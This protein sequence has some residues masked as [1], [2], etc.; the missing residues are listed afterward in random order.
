MTDKNDGPAVAEPDSVVSEEDIELEAEHRVALTE[1]LLEYR[2]LRT[3]NEYDP[4]EDRAYIE[5]L[6][7]KDLL[8]FWDSLVGETINKI[9]QNPK[10]DLHDAWENADVDGIIAEPSQW[11]L[12][13]LLTGEETDYVIPTLINVLGQL[14][15]DSSS[16]TFSH[17]KLE[18]ML[19][20]CGM[21]VDEDGYIIDKE[22][23]EFKIPYNFDAH[24]DR[25]FKPFTETAY[26][27]EDDP[28]EERLAD[29]REEHD[30]PNRHHSDRIHTEDFG[31][32]IPSG[33]LP[34]TEKDQIL[35]DYWYE[36]L[37]LALAEA[38]TENLK[39]IGPDSPILT[40]HEIYLTYTQDAEAFAA[41]E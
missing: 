23:G 16:I 1:D 41:E 5:E 22:T 18:F 39:G 6:S 30:E 40:T 2:E 21:A 20:V 26:D 35:K 19:E 38:L 8:L 24:G 31:G 33:I 17:S 29:M 15:Q 12:K 36:M 13:K 25:T 11:Q 28:L 9:A 3:E 4:D 37:E 14:L 10:S 32:V 7:D 34:N 27:S